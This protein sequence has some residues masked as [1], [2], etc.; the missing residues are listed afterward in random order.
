MGMTTTAP[1]V[2]LADL[3]ALKRRAAADP[4]IATSPSR[5]RRLG[6][7][8]TLLRKAA[9]DCKPA[10][11][12]DL[13]AYLHA[14]TIGH[15]DQDESV[16][17]RAKTGRYRQHHLGR[18]L[19]A[20]SQRH[21]MDG[22]ADLNRAAGLPPY[23]WQQRGKRPWSK[24]TEEPID[25][26]GH[27]VLRR[28][29]CEPATP[30]R[31]PFRLRTLLAVELLWDTGVPPQGLVQ[32]DTTDLAPDFSRIELTVNPPGRTTATRQTFRLKAPTRAALKLWLPVRQTVVAE[33]LS[34]GADHR[35]NQALFITLHPTVGTDDEGRERLIPPGLRISE[36]GL[37]VSCAGWLRWLNTVHSGEGWPVPTTLQQLA[38]GGAANRSS[39]R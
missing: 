39:R 33:H 4:A 36:Q 34:A 7:V 13:A 32:A 22:I 3:D 24:H 20:A 16:L 10:Q 18:P 15:P 17:G 21:I 2:L 19:T 30:R 29:L 28:A 37:Q 11:L 9:A 14:D 5:V 26:G 23:W 1:D 31:E 12:R 35:S 25:K 6:A 38:R 8:T 27:Q